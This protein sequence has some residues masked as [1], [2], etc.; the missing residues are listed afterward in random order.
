MTSCVTARDSYF[1]SIG[2]I[3]CGVIAYTGT[4]VAIFF[5]V[6]GKQSEEVCTV[7]NIGVSTNCR[8]FAF[9]MA[10]NTKSTD[11]MMPPAAE[12]DKY[13]FYLPGGRL[14]NCVD[15]EF[16]VDKCRLPEVVPCQEKGSIKFG[17]REGLPTVTE[18]TWHRFT[19]QDLLATVKGDD[20]PDC[21]KK[22]SVSLVFG[23]QGW[24]VIRNK[25]CIQADTLL[26]C[27]IPIDQKEW[28]DTFKF[29]LF[30]TLESSTIKFT[31]KDPDN[32]HTFY[33]TEQVLKKDYCFPLLDVNAYLGQTYKCRNERP[34]APYYSSVSYISL[35]S[36]MV[37]DIE[38]K[39][40]QKSLSGCIS[41]GDTPKVCV[42]HWVQATIQPT[43][44]QP[45]YG[46]ANSAPVGKR[47]YLSTAHHRE[48]YNSWIAVHD[49]SS[50]QVW[51][52]VMFEW[53]FNFDAHVEGG[54]KLVFAPDSPS[55]PQKPEVQVYTNGDSRTLPIPDFPYKV[56]ETVNNYY[57]AA[58]DQC[59]YSW[60]H[61]C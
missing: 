12:C 47:C 45:H 30:Q 32:P 48:R 35:S 33:T 44:S 13:A 53:Y 19:A 26:T 3:L 55:T 41:L 50:N 40:S 1:L 7:Q 23:N 37:K 54:N 60:V 6:S 46:S 38:A 17:Q 51:P 28:T 9:I 36:E 20:Q 58:D 4:I 14:P 18:D 11:D 39:P 2:S 52:V 22:Q 61:H 8:D 42:P 16:P 29:A 27:G 43:S 24:K 5:S 59:I 57:V 15:Y 21:N 10:T 34:W 49:T 25:V 31:Y 56:L